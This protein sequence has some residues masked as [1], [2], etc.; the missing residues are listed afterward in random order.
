M[1]HCKTFSIRKKALENDNC[2]IFIVEFEQRRPLTKGSKQ[3]HNI[4]ICLTKDKTR[5]Y[6]WLSKY[7]VGQAFK[8]MIIW[9]TMILHIWKI[10]TT[11]KLLYPW[12]WPENYRELPWVWITCKLCWYFLHTLWIAYKSLLSLFLKNFF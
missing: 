3:E 9:I 12:G 1:I 4:M 2:K 7:G 8:C 6:S 11:N 10:I 5:S